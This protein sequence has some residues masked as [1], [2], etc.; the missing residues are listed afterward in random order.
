VET[1]QEA[2]GLAVL[3]TEPT[4]TLQLDQALQIQVTGGEVVDIHLVVLKVAQVG[5]GL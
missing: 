2:Q 4:T 5:K 3:E 1:Q